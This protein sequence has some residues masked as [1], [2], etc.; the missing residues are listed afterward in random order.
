MSGEAFIAACEVTLNGE[1][2]SVPAGCT[3]EALVRQQG[4]QPHEVATALNGEF[5]PRA[6]RATRLLTP[7]D[8]VTCFRTIVGG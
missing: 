1:S 4:L 8:A 5:V 3:L 7:G 6:L 2:F